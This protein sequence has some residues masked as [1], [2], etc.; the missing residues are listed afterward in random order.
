[1]PLVFSFLLVYDFML[2]FIWKKKQLINDRGWPNLS[3]HSTENNLMQTF[4]VTVTLPSAI[5]V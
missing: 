5:L 3:D 1:M 4:T 2:F